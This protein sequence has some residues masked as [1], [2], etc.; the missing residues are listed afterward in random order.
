MMDLPIVLIDKKNIHNN[1][2]QVINQ[3]VVDT[4]DGAN[5]DNRY[6]VT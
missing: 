4:E 6:D 1:S 3:Y 2:L 5:H